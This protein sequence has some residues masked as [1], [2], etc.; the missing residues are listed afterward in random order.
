MNGAK[1]GIRHNIFWFCLMIRVFGFEP[2]LAGLDQW[3]LIGPYGSYH[4][5]PDISPVD[6]TRQMVAAIRN[7][8]ILDSD[9]QEWKL[10]HRFDTGFINGCVRSPWQTDDLY[11]WFNE[12]GL[13]VSTDLG[14]TWQNRSPDTDS[15]G[16]K[17]FSFDYTTPGHICATNSE[18]I[19]ESYDSGITWV[20]VNSPVEYS[21][22]S[23]IMFFPDRQ[24]AMVFTASSSSYVTTDH[25]VTWQEIPE[26][27]SVRFLPSF[28][29]TI[30][31]MKDGALF[32]C[33]LS[34]LTLR[35]IL[36]PASPIFN[37]Q[38]DKQR[39]RLYCSTPA[40]LYYTDDLGTTWHQAFEKD[41]I[42]MICA[43]GEHVLVR[44]GI[45]LYRSV[46]DAEDFVEVTEGIIGLRLE[47]LDI[48]CNDP[49]RLVAHE[50]STVYV[51]NSKHSN[52]VNH[53]SLPFAAS[54]VR[55][56]CATDD[57]MIAKT[58]NSD[59]FFLISIDLAE[60]FHPF[61]E[62]LQP[63]ENRYNL[64]TSRILYSPIY[65][66]SYYTYQFGCNNTGYGCAC[67]AKRHPDMD[68]WEY[69]ADTGKR[70]LGSIIDDPNHPLRLYACGFSIDYNNDCTDPTI[71]IGDF[72][73]SDDAGINWTPMVA[74][75]DTLDGPGLSI[76]RC[77]GNPSTYLIGTERSIYW[78]DPEQNISKLLTSN[79]EY[80]KSGLMPLDKTG[81]DY[82][83]IE[84]KRLVRSGRYRNFGSPVAH[85][86]FLDAHYIQDDIDPYHLYCVGTDLAVQ[87]IT[88]SR[89][90][91]NV[92][93][94]RDV[95][96]AWVD[97]KFEIS[98]GPSPGYSTKV[99]IGE[100]PGDYSEMV[101]SPE[102]ENRTEYHVY[103]V[104]DI[105]Y[106]RLT[107]CHPS[108]I[109][110]EYSE[111]VSGLAGEPY[112]LLKVGGHSIH[113]NEENRYGLISAYVLPGPSAERIQ[114]VVVRFEGTKLM[115]LYDYGYDGDQIEDDFV[116]AREF[117]LP[118]SVPVGMYLYT[119]DAQDDKG[120]FAHSW[121]YLRVK[122]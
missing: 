104:G 109:E 93:I 2:A 98:W 45:E 39:A 56:E 81:D 71:G 43:S 90:A 32:V 14:I 40:A 122:D 15:S 34:D 116:F 23:S 79:T 119:I 105:M 17:S 33:S 44:S 121:P 118:S 64:Y 20:P 70:V 9:T 82:L 78:Y 41:A 108:G 96:V 53:Q 12:G 24:D 37:F 55:F 68:C 50:G 51:R 66:A 77:P 11:V 94:P 120:H 97:G 83:Y 67:I 106:F 31:A 42:W 27:D 52:W 85:G 111:E 10:F 107:H 22:S 95:S 87:E 100:N 13:E 91:E 89:H 65:I 35:G 72:Y 48:S 80:K 101:F 4:S 76:V 1:R 8:F 46:N 57:R 88:L 30:W 62:N 59:S 38:M 113:W 102:G 16:R 47:S 73:R 114:N 25:G 49:D 6:P 54:F 36:I 86:S 69:T 61:D 115:T 112:P 5:I 29:G 18:L 63:Q 75:G 26:S 7:V 117:S 84:E 60:T 19:M 103:N 28:D 92:P 58:D 21:Y 74:S 110:S 99:H 3:D